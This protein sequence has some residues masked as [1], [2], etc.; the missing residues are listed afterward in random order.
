MTSKNHQFGQHFVA[1]GL[2][3]LVLI[4]LLWDAQKQEIWEILQTVQWKWLLLALGIKS[5][6]LFIHEYRL[7][8]SLSHPRPKMSTTMQIGFASALI[9][10]LIPAR[11]G[12]VVA[13]ALLK[14][15]CHIPTSLGT[16]A[17]GMVSF[18]EAAV[19]GTLMMIMLL[20]KAPIWIPLMGE[21]ILNQTLNTIT[22]ATLLGIVAVTSAVIIGRRLHPKEDEV[23]SQS[24]FSPLQWIQKTLHHAGDNL[25]DLRYL[26]NN[27][28]ASIIEVWLMIAAFALIFPALNIAIIDPWTISGLILGISAVASIVLP[29][30][31]AAG[32]T[33]SAIFVLTL[34]QIDESAAIAYSTL[35]WIIS[36]VP[37]AILGIP[38]LWRLQ[39]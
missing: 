33:A 18:F 24:S 6:S 14:K 22:I 13:I 10:I 21:S 36:Q 37:A 11:A 30:T 26:L 39:Q 9:N 38:S 5:I 28:M 7:W 8:T 4:L 3:L 29:P 23:S 16:F 25:T 12:D 19:F 20:L 27:T 15:H 35:W 17:V 2:S 31:Y 1:F 32:N 34:F